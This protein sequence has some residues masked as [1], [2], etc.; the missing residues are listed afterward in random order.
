MAKDTLNEKLLFNAPDFIQVIFA[1]S[2]QSLHI[3]IVTLILSLPGQ[4]LQTYWYYKCG[5]ENNV[6]FYDGSTI[7]DNSTQIK[8]E[9]Q[10][11]PNRNRA[12]ADSFFNSHSNQVTFNWWRMPGWCCYWFFF[13][14]NVWYVI[15]RDRKIN[16]C[17]LFTFPS[18][19]V[20]CWL[21]PLRPQNTTHWDH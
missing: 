7:L 16:Y 12:Y 2:V 19:L 15:S 13:R 10:V 11:C 4:S 6:L 20:K 9:Y 21:S 3:L 8:P 1:N 17:I 5:K 14:A 18:Q